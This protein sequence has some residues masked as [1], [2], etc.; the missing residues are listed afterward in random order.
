M[1][2]AF[3]PYFFLR[4]AAFRDFV[5]TS[6]YRETLLKGLYIGPVNGHL[7][8]IWR[9]FTHRHVLFFLTILLYF[10]VHT[11]NGF[12]CFKVASA[13]DSHRLF[14]EGICSFRSEFFLQD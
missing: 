4:G 13:L 5:F 11:L 8:Q 14:R 2:S 1:N 6:L 3:L 12:A 10:T 7:A 9:I